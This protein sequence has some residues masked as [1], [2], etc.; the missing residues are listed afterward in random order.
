MT[1]MLLFPFPSHNSQNSNL[2]S[3]KRYYRKQK[4]LK[5]KN[6]LISVFVLFRALIFCS[7]FSIK[8]GPTRASFSFFSSFQTNITILTTNKCEKCPS[9]IR[10]QDSNSQ[11][12]DYETPPLTTRPGLPIFCSV[13]S[14]FILTWKFFKTSLQPQ[15]LLLGSP[16]RM[17]PIHLSKQVS[18]IQS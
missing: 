9:R 1:M 16:M 8:N 5:F 2:V 4:L 11:P 3:F 17:D 13:W 14:L 10:H 12:F 18:N 6:V 15:S 7:V